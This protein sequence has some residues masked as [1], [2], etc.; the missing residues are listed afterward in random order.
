MKKDMEHIQQPTATTCVHAC[1]AMLAG[2]SVEGVIEKYGHPDGVY[3][4]EESS[5]AQR[6]GLDFIK[7]HTDKVAPGRVY[8]ITVPSLNIPN[9]LHRVVVDYREAENPVV[10]D[11]N[12]GKEGKAHY[13]CLDSIPWWKDVT[14]YFP[15]LVG[16]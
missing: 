5:F 3:E 7:Y 8:L 10:L 4:W 9:S 14:E 12:M 15:D 1:L 11:P 2:V 6:M 13:D 16:E